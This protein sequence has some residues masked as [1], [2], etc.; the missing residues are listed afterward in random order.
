M[1]VLRA[2]HGSAAPARAGGDERVW[3][4][5]DVGPAEAV[6]ERYG[7]GIGGRCAVFEAGGRWTEESKR[8]FGEACGQLSS[9][10]DFCVPSLSL[11]F[12]FLLGFVGYAAFF[13]LF[14]LFFSFLFFLSGLY[15]VW[16]N[17][18]II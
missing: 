13:V 14:S 1:G 6:S 2:S 4:R 3:R 18:H 7:A 8:G 9:V 12:L 15:F 10:D 16:H 17:M 11:F 5:C